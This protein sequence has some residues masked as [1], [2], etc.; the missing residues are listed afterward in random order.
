MCSLEKAKELGFEF[1]GDI[2][3]IST[4]IGEGVLVGLSDNEKLVERLKSIKHF[5]ITDDVTTD[6]ELEYI[7]GANGYITVYSEEFD[8]GFDIEGDE[9][10][11]LIDALNEYSK[12]INGDKTLADLLE[13]L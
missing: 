8:I 2:V 4:S 3:P 1:I 10:R 6:S 9:K 7:T 5:R 12:S 11:I 13:E